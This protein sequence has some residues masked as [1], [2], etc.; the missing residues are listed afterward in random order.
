MVRLELEIL[1]LVIFYQT[2]KL[3]KEKYKNI[4]I[5]EILYKT[6]TG[7]KP[8]RIRFDQIDR[9]IKIHDKITYSVLF[10]YKYCDKIYDKIEYLISEKS[11]ITDSINHNFARI[12]ID[13]NDSLHAGKN[14]VFHNVIIVIKS[15]VKKNTNN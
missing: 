8:L 14:I 2:K 10:D 9:L 4:L 15:V 13:P 5:Y 11:G 12:R 6:S 7:A 3:Y 1:I